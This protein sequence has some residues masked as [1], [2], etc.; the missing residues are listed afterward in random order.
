MIIIII[1]IFIKIEKCYDVWNKIYQI[2]LSWR[3]NS[4]GGDSVEAKNEFIGTKCI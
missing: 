2:M 3:I 1:I 4:F